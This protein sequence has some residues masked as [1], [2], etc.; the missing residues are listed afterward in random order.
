MTDFSLV[1]ATMGGPYLDSAIRSY[2]QT[3]TRLYELCIGLDAVGDLTTVMK[4]KDTRSARIG[5]ALAPG[6]G[7]AIQAGVDM[8]TRDWLIVAHDDIV[9]LPGWDDFLDDLR[10]DRLMRL[11]AL[12]PKGLTWPPVVDAGDSFHDYRPAVAEAAIRPKRPFQAGGPFLDVVTVCHRSRWMPWPDWP[13]RY[14]THDTA[15]WMETSRR[16]P[17]L[18]HGWLPGRC[19]YH[20]ISGSVRDRVGDDP[21]GTFESRYG[22]SAAAASNMIWERS[23]E[24]HGA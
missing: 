9:F 17:D 11:E 19:V 4:S 1:I 3:Q 2:R 12:D 7:R 20:F 6:M 14:G 13:G 18:I 5:R 21:P 10:E 22:M 16:H 24:M 15:W 23:K 8:T